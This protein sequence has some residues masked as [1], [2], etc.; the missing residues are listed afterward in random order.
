MLREKGIQNQETQGQEKKDQE[1]KGK[2]GVGGNGQRAEPKKK[3]LKGG[4]KRP[5]YP[6][7]PHEEEHKDNGVGKTMINGEA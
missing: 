2:T 6:T 1:L 4:E 5:G 7:N 3:R